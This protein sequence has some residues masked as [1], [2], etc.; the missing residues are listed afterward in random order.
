M[1]EIKTHQWKKKEE[2]KMKERGKRRRKQKIKK[3]ERGAEKFA[4]CMS[5]C[6]HV[7][8]CVW[9]HE[10]QG[11]G[12]TSMLGDAPVLVATFW[13]FLPRHCPE[14]TDSFPS[15][16]FPFSKGAHFL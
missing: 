4:V 6:V 13:P 14:P 10:L 3:Q 11:P 8:V 5:A 12:R 2:E 9:L 16:L 15:F 7:C 1:A